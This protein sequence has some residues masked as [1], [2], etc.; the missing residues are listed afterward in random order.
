MTAL[1]FAKQTGGSVFEILL[2]S[3]L[4]SST[5]AFD[6]TSSMRQ[7]TAPDEITI[8]NAELSLRRGDHA[9]TARICRAILKN[10]PRDPDALFL[11]GRA[12]FAAAEGLAVAPVA[13][14]AY[15][16]AEKSFLQLLQVAPERDETRIRQSLA[17]CAR[18]RGAHRE[19][20]LHARKAVE[21]GSTNP[22][23]L[24]VLGECASEL[25]RKEEALRSFQESHRLKP[26]DIDVVHLLAISLRDLERPA[27]AC[28]LLEET[29][30]QLPSPSDAAVQLLLVLYTTHLF[31]N[32]P[33]RAQKVIEQAATM[34]PDDLRAAVEL[35][36]NLYRLGQ[37]SRA[38][39]VANRA[40]ALPDP[41]R[42]Q[43]G[44]I[45]R[46]LG[47]LHA[48]DG[49]HVAA[50]QE[51][52]QCIEATPDDLSALLSLAGSLRRIGEDDRAREVLKIHT[53]TREAIS[54]VD[55]RP[56]P[57]L[58]Q[59][60]GLAAQVAFIRAL[61]Y[62]DR[63]DEAKMQLA[64]REAIAPADPANG[65]LQSLIQTQEPR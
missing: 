9:A 43:R 42:R 65:S 27:Q 49:E 4:L 23:A 15:R 56:L 7:Q 14:Q 24:R 3:T 58:S 20:L 61:V 8:R 22:V 51:L 2:L 40:R 60:P 45:A 5:P 19:A 31:T 1:V 36:T 16:E 62:L 38:K 48:H 10:K 34:A 64:R 35:A 12:S 39:E 54:L 47:Q 53:Q 52:D 46:I 17:L 26:S 37:H 21:L 50:I 55:R 29:I 32:D 25:G 28:R 6:L 44:A 33:D 63:I 57:D 13:L 41:T 11:L 30:D 59:A 18:H